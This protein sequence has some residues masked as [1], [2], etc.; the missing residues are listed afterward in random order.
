MLNIINILQM[1][2]RSTECVLF[3]VTIHYSAFTVQCPPHIHLQYSGQF[4]RKREANEKIELW[5]E[6]QVILPPRPRKPR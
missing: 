3:T 6:Q 2:T 1:I 4:H 5:K